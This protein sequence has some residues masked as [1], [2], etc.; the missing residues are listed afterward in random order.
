MVEGFGDVGD[1][2][3]FVGYWCCFVVVDYNGL[4]LVDG[5]F[6]LELI[7]FVWSLIWVGVIVLVLFLICNDSIF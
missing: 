1:E 6:C 3:G 4:G 7:S 2:M 5:E